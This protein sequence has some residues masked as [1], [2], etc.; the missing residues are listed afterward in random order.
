[1]KNL[2]KGMFSIEVMHLRA[3]AQACRDTAAR[4]SLIADRARLIRM[5]ERLE[6]AAQALEESCCGTAGSPGIR[7]K[8]E[9]V[10]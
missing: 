2:C 1:M 3:E 9:E 8:P 4:L 7:V 6:A 5:A 10:G